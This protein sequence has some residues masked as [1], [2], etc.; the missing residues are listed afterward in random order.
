MRCSKCASQSTTSNSRSRS[1]GRKG[2]QYARPAREGER[3][4]DHSTECITQEWE[5][6]DGHRWVVKYYRACWCGW[7][8]Q[9][10]EIREY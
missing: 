1:Y 3:Q 8:Y 10:P 4:H 2:L 5:C 9:E 6:T 7:M